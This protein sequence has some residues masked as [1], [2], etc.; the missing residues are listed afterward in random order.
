MAISTV[1]LFQTAVYYS[2]VSCVEWDNKVIEVLV[3]EHGEK[4]HYIY[5]VQKF[6]HE[7]A[8]LYNL[9]ETEK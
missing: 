5:G 7:S 1:I 4:L 9:D 2:Y 6:P 8:S 3:K